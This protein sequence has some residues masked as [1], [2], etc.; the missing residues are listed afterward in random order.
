MITEKIVIALTAFPKKQNFSSTSGFFR[1]L[2]NKRPKTAVFLRPVEVPISVRPSPEMWMRQAN[3]ARGCWQ[4]RVSALSFKDWR[5]KKLRKKHKCFQSV[6]NTHQHTPVYWRNTSYLFCVLVQDIF[7]FLEVPRQLFC[8]C[9][10]I[11]LKIAFF[12]KKGAV[13]PPDSVCKRYKTAALPESLNWTGYS[14]LVPESYAACNAFSFAH[15]A[16]NPKIQGYGP[17]L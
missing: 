9:L 7:S 8:S 4:E 16:L 2:C 13:Q 17:A 11:F 5:K 6:T 15:I 12:E 10:G 14:E 3:S 1:H